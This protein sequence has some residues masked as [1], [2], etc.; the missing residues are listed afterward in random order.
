MKL[1][2]TILTVTMCEHSEQLKDLSPER[3]RK[4][5]DSLEERVPSGLASIEKW[6]ELLMI[7]MGAP[8][9]SE[10]IAKKLLDFLR[11]K[12]YKQ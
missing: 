5:A 2:D 7:F 8:A 11:G 9:E 12:Q 3:K 6:N 1:L 10:K 4:L